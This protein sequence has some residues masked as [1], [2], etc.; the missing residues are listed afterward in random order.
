MKKALGFV[1]KRRS[2]DTPFDLGTICSGGFIAIFQVIRAKMVQE[3]SKI[4]IS[5]RGM[6]VERTINR[7]QVVPEFPRI[8]SAREF[9]FKQNVSVVPC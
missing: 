1:S 3:F 6:D 8:S 5:T 9:R 2:G 4:A 7:P